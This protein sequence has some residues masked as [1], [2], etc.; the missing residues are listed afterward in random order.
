MKPLGVRDGTSAP[1]ARLASRCES[2]SGEVSRA[3]QRGPVHA[4]VSE[5]S[6]ARLVAGGGAAERL[7][8]SDEDDPFA[9]RDGERPSREAAGRSR[10]RG[11]SE[12]ERSE[13]L[14]PSPR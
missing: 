1:R 6:G 11:A 2:D 10:V 14:E 8:R 4:G 9:E 5:P 3:G 12:A 13:G 7:G